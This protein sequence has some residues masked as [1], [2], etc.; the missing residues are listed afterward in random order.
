MNK[1][2]QVLTL[3]A[4]MGLSGTAN[5]ALQTRLGGLALYDTDLNITW[6]A[7]AN[8]AMTSGYDADGLMTWSQAN[9]WAA[10]LSVGGFSGWRL[11]TTLQPDATC[12]S[13]WYGGTQSGGRDCTDSEMGHLFYTELGGVTNQSITSTH[14]ANYGLFQNVQSDRYWSGTEYTR[15]TSYAWFFN[16][17]L[18]DQ[19]GYRKISDVYALAV[20]PGDVAAVSVPAAAWLLGSGLLGLIGVARRKACAMTAE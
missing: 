14:N 5:A 7:D 11:P 9:T 19:D 17:F 13:Q 10:G 3:I 2:L 12:G 1:P 6:L 16:F 15:D 8:Y 20:R 4:A 18:G